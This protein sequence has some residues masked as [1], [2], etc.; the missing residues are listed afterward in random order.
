LDEKAKRRAKKMGFESAADRLANDPRLRE[1]LTAHY[2]AD[3]M[4]GRPK[5]PPSAPVAKAAAALVAAVLA[6]RPPGAA[7][8]RE[9]AGNRHTA[10]DLYLP[11]ASG[12]VVS[13]GLLI[14][15]MLA[16]FMV[17]CMCG[18]MFCP[19]CRQCRRFFFK[20]MLYLAEGDLRN[21]MVRDVCV[22]SQ[23][24]YTW[25]SPAPRFLAGNQGFGAA[26]TVDV[27]SVRQVQKPHVE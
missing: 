5:A 2:G 19:C 24:T 3:L 20:I 26:G 18:C 4:A 16:I 23:T 22:Q 6:T 15:T 8:E 13:I 27:G 7:G 10:I 12:T 9:M 17:G 21:M 25:S 14:I 1:S 11:E